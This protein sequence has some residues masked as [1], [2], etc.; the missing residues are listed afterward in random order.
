MRHPQKFLIE[1]L[2]EIAPLSSACVEANT[3]FRS[4]VTRER[5]GFARLAMHY[6]STETIEPCKILGFLLE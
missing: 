4:P 6:F 5:E 1:G 3:F 2:Q